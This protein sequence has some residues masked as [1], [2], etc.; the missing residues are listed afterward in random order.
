YA[1]VADVHATLIPAGTSDGEYRPGALPP[2][3]PTTLVGRRGDRMERAR[4]FSDRA[5][6]VVDKT[7]NLITLEATDAYLRW[8]ETSDKVARTR[9]AATAGSRLATNTR[10][11]FRSEQ[12]VKIEDVLTNE[13][14][15]GQ[16]RSSANEALY[17][18]VL[19]LAALERVTAG[20]FPSGLGA[21]K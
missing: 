15:A 10:D 13:V 3:M 5:A 14:L 16:A 17:Q 19:A 12:K 21:R 18:N 11:D 20:G 9:D 7:R 6:A 2:E 4:D 1:A 8:K